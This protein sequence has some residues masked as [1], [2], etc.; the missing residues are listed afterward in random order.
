LP[1]FVFLTYLT[2]LY[3]RRYSIYEASVEE[4]KVILKLADLWEFKQVKELAVRELHKK[5]E[6]KLVDRLALY[7]HYKVDSRHLIPLYGLL[8][9]RDSPLTL[10]ESKILGLDTTVLIATMREQLRA[11]PSNEGRSSLPE[12]LEMPDV[13]RALE[14]ELELEEGVTAEFY[15]ASNLPLPTGMCPG[16]SPRKLF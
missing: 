16:F 8:C 2:Y 10:P 9:S 15:R 12:N 7:Q 3:Q 4:W 6:L 13:Y 11:L 14:K 5:P 1:L